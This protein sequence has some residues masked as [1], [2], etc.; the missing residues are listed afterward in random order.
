ML[1][2][3]DPHVSIRV[4]PYRHASFRL[5][6]WIKIN[7]D[8]IT[9]KVL[10]AVEDSLRSHFSFDQRSFGQPVTLS[11]VISIIQGVSGVVAADVRKLY[12][13]DGVPG[14][15][16]FLGADTTQPGYQ[17]ELELSY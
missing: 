7:P 6:A 17:S 2:F 1:K 9:N 10:A 3:G 14:A 13:V 12:R 11:E 5:E 4:L 15:N 8:Y 16:F